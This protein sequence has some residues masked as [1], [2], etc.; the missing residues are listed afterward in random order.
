MFLDFSPKVL[1][2]EVPKHQFK[3]CGVVLDEFQVGF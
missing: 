2:F 3:R 1:C